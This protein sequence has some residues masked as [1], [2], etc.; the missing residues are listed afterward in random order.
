VAARSYFKEERI[1]KNNEFITRG[2]H[3]SAEKY[4]HE[5]EKIVLSKVSQ[6]WMLPL[7]LNY[8]NELVNG[9]LAPVG[10]DEGMVRIT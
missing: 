4:F 8:I 10:I 5:Y 6:G 9:E 2:N 7:P 3:K 1:A